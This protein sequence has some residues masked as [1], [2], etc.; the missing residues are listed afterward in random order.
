MGPMVIRVFPDGRPVPGD[1]MRP[2]PQDE[3]LDDLQYSKVPTVSEIET[4]AERIFYKKPY[5]LIKRTSL[6]HP[7]NQRISFI[8]KNHYYRANPIFFRLVK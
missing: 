8:T 5:A 6:S 4:K 1:D 7:A 3:D 2:L